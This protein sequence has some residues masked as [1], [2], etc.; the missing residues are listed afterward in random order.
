MV[1]DSVLL[2]NV[3]TSGTVEHVVTTVEELKA[4]NVEAPTAPLTLERALPA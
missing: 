3:R 1:G 4:T 2:E